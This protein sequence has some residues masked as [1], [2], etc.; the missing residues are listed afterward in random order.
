MI[1]QKAIKHTEKIFE[2][3]NKNLAHFIRPVI[4]PSFS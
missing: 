1:F 4:D 3:P 2:K